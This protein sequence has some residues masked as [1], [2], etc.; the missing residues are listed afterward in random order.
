M[1]YSKN[2]FTVLNLWTTWCKPCR[3]EI[4]IV[5][6]QL[7][8]KSKNKPTSQIGSFAICM[9]FGAGWTP[10]I[11]PILTGILTIAASSTSLW[12]GIQL[13]SFYTLGLAVHFFISALVIERFITFFKR[14][15][16]WLPWIN[17]ISG[18]ILITIGIISFNRSTKPLNKLCSRY[19]THLPL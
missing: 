12:T 1:I 18:I 11:G 6:R 3:E 10:Y 9:S 13:L 14:M 8:F 5:E 4:P 7:G 2:N 17:R 16:K 15:R 19:G